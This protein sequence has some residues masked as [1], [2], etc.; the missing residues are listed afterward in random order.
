VD[1]QSD[2]PEISALTTA[3]NHLLMRVSASNERENARATPKLFCRLGDRIHEAVL[4]TP[5]G[6]PVRQPSVLRPLSGVDR[7]ELGGA[8]LGDLV[9]PSTPISSMRTCGAVRPASV[10]ERYED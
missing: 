10:G 6:H 8:Q 9:P 7:I 2:Q 5:R 3:V 4:G 1:L